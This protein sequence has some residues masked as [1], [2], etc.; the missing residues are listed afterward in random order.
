MRKF[1]TLLF[2]FLTALSISAQSVYD[3]LIINEIQVC[4]TDLYLDPSNNYGAWIEL[5]NT[6]TQVI[7][8]AGLY[9][10]DDKENPKKFKI[11]G[12]VAN[13]KAGAFRCIWFD[14]NQADGNYG[15]QSDQQVRFK[16][17][18]EGGAIYLFD[19]QG[20][21]ICKVEYPAGIPRCSYARTED[22]G[23][24]WGTT[25]QP[26]PG[27]SNA[28]S[29][30]ATER[31]P[32]PHLSKEG[33]VFE[34]GKKVRLTVTIPEGATLAYTT[35]GSTPTLSNGVVSNERF[36][37]LTIEQTTVLRFATFQ[38]GYLPSPVATRSFI[39]KNHDYYLP[40]LSVSTHPDNL[41]DNTIGVYC[42]GTNGIS[43]K[44]QSEPK[45][46]NMDWERPVNMEYMVPEKNSDGTTSFTT[47]INQEVDLE[48]CGGWTRAYGGN[49]TDGHYWEAKPSFRL[50]TDKEYE[51]I[52]VLDYPVFPHKPYNKYKVWQ[53]R[54][55]GNDTYAR[56]IDT[57]VAQIAI[58]SDYNL[59]AQ[60]CQPAHIFLNGQYLGMFNIRES[61][62]RHYGYSNWGID[63][64][65][66]DQFELS[67]GIRMMVGTEDAWKELVNLGLQ[68]SKDQ[69][70]DT[71]QQVC[72]RLCIDEFA[73]FM[74][75][76]LYL[77]PSDWITNVN[78]IKAYRS[79]S[80][81]GKFRF[82]LFDQDSSFSSDHM[83]QS[84]MNGN[85]GANVDDL[86]RYLMSYP[87]FKKKFVDAFCLVDG[88]L[89]DPE[90]CEEIVQEIYNR[91]NRALNFEGNSSNTDVAK[92]A[93]SMHNGSRMTN[94]QS[95]LSLPQPYF[96]EISSNIPQ[97]QLMLNEQIIPTGKFQGFLYPID[98]QIQ[99]TAQ[100]PAGYTFDGWTF[101]GSD[102]GIP[103]SSTDVIPYGASWEYYD[104]GSMDG[105]GWQEPDFD[106]S[107][108]GWKSGRAPLGYGKS[109]SNIANKT[110]TQL[111]YGGDS[112]NKRPTYYFRYMFDID[113]LP[114]EDDVYELH[115]KVD[116][117]FRFYLNGKDINGFRCPSG[118]DYDYVTNDWAGDQPDTGIFTIDPA[119]LTLG[120]N[121]L[122][123]EVHNTSLTSSDIFWDA[124]LLHLTYET[125]NENGTLS[126]ESF[127]LA[128][129]V[130][131]G[132]YIITAHYSPV[133]DPEQLL[134][135][136]ITPIR[137]NE[138]SAA[139]DI[140]INDLGKRNDWVELYNTTDQ[141]IDVAG[142]YLSDKAKKPQK[143][144]ITN[145]GHEDAST[146]IPPHGTLIIWCDQLEA[147]NQL[148]A[149]FKLDNAD[150]ASVSIQDQ[151]GRWNDRLDYME[152][153]RWQTFGRY[154]D[155]GNF[156][157]LMT[158]P[159]IDS[160]NLMSSYDYTQD[161]PS[162]WDD[163]LIHITID[164]AQGWNWTSHNL[165]TD[166][167]ISRFTSAAQEVVGQ[168]N[169]YK[170]DPESGEWTGGL[171]GMEAGLGY[172]LCC[173]APAQVTLRGPLFA[174]STTP[175][176]ISKGWNWIGCPL[177][178]TTTLQ[179]ALAQFSPSEGDVIVGLDEIATFED[180]QWE[181][182]LTSVQPGQA[183]LY[184]SQ[185]DNTLYWNALSEGNAAP[186]QYRAAQARES[187]VWTYDIHAYPHVESLIA[188]L[189]T[190]KTDM[191]TPLFVGAFAGDECR[192]VGRWDGEQLLFNIHGEQPDSLTFRLLDAEGNTFTSKT[193]FT[194]QPQTV[195]G[196]R[197]APFVLDFN[198]QDIEDLI[199]MP[200]MGGKVVERSYYNLQGQQMES[201]QGI[202][203]EKCLM[204]DGSMK[205][206]KIRK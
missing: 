184:K 152:Q 164:L 122:A 201:P 112:N 13:L 156:T 6:G 181:G 175:V 15:G 104:Q 125:N 101:A 10:T 37:Y 190:D 169:A 5:H 132:S 20:S 180:G 204:S 55:G 119:D 103:T 206:R 78:N 165:A 134:A 127:N 50:K 72:D 7:K 52:N 48:I 173:P 108:Q 93:R 178:H 128:E 74:A 113:E 38:D 185:R 63:T 11:P 133:T 18:V 182:T 163:G 144:Q 106:S 109:G 183:Y 202:C 172:K 56:I 118:C 53:V 192:G 139:N 145:A 32:M 161:L 99:L 36:T 14:H 61:N 95:V 57:S 120:T 26:T 85:Y 136:G 71:Y 1:I 82:V 62:N 158:W 187:E 67:G 97:A 90:R 49:T 111:S 200:S 171:D 107:S 153:P 193:Q 42:T 126:S 8:L 17:S 46:W 194:F 31:L 124:Q 176:A 68:L 141:E 19:S 195:L 86:F 151:Y 4:N 22:G 59:D 130:P 44:G 98:Q 168:K 58:R 162:Q 29:L 150:G 87:P 205:V 123:V 140:Y 80:D 43:G 33:G 197:M 179:S 159:T 91:T 105:M 60:D 81:G 92:K 148:H 69:S 138:V 77:G 65:D 114:S 88:S 24:T 137:I 131:T 110:V 198:P 25:G 166:V 40:V 157:T 174:F 96:A 51:G 47:Y 199:A 3:N 142:M 12:S 76:G 27:S 54:N 21:Q 177:F 28:T 155:G 135:D 75:Y 154:P 116:D 9:V 64:D 203:I 41:F 146:V 191:D 66:M 39:F 170:K 143:W 16:P 79:R 115:Y 188:T 117:G 102:K 100:A 189:Q 23:K 149:P 167:H 35:D 147:A 186:R 30:F 45:N 94:M 2:L 129:A 83:L 89:F 70:E 34:Q 73:N 196:S 121:V 84:V 160:R